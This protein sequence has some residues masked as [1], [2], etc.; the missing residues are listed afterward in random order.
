MDIDV[1]PTTSELY[2]DWR[3]ALAPPMTKMMWGGI[4]HFFKFNFKLINAYSYMEL[5]VVGLIKCP[6]MC[7]NVINQEID[8]GKLVDH[9]GGP[10]P[11]CER[12]TVRKRMICSRAF[13]NFSNDQFF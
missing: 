7:P 5:A 13:A 3:C 10:P 2:T 8:R 12:T 9:S 4:G 6:D 11:G 1:K